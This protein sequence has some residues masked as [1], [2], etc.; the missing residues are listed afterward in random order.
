MEVG[1]QIKM[2]AHDM[3]KQFLK[4]ITNFEDFNLILTLFIQCS[5]LYHK[6]ARAYVTCDNLIFFCNLGKIENVRC[7]HLL[8]AA[9][10]LN[11][12]STI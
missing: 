5:F 9:W 10:S 3:Y 8:V 6:S 12:I 1:H 7:E 4:I 2:L 11:C